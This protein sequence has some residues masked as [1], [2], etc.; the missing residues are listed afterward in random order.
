MFK[1]DLEDDEDEDRLVVRRVEVEPKL[2]CRPTKA[3]ASVVAVRQADAP[4]RRAL[5]ENFMLLLR[6]G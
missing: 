4:R 2:L 5:V 3:K 6:N 1:D